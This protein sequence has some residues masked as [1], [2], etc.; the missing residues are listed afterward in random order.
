MDRRNRKESLSSFI[1]SRKKGL[2]TIKRVIKKNNF[3]TPKYLRKRYQLSA[4]GKVVKNFKI[5]QMN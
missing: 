5:L 2:K 4:I 1:S 3:M